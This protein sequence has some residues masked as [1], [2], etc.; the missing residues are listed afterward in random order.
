MWSAGDGD[1]LKGRL[2]SDVSLVGMSMCKSLSMS[3][4]ELLLADAGVLLVF[5]SG[6]G[7]MSVVGLGFA[8]AARGGR[9]R[10]GGVFLLAFMWTVLCFMSALGPCGLNLALVTTLQGRVLP[11]EAWYRVKNPCLLITSSV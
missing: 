4:L 10:V 2:K 5:P 3:G 8:F 9:T 7:V 6:E 1:R 11:T